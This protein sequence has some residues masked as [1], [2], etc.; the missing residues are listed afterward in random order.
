MSLNNLIEN[1]IRNNK[2]TGFDFSKSIESN[3]FPYTNDS[4]VHHFETGES[5]PIRPE[6]TEWNN[7]NSS[8][9]NMLTRTF[10]FKSVKHLLYFINDIIKKSEQL[11]H[12]PVININNLN[13]KIFL[14]THDIDDVSDLDISMS[15]YI[16]EVYKD[17][18]FIRSL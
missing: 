17:V 12:H 13:I 15:K 3:Q 7:I 5:V 6:S 14:Y 10:M 2:N 4:M 18:S 8:N 9:I 1:I 11:N 16:D